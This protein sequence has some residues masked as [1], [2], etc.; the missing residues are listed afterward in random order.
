MCLRSQLVC[1][2]FTHISL[3]PQGN[4]RSLPESKDRI[5]HC[6]GV[7]G[8]KRN[9]TEPQWK[10]TGNVETFSTAVGSF[11]RALSIQI[12]VSRA[13][14]CI[15][16][17]R[18]PGQLGNGKENAAWGSSAILGSHHWHIGL[19]PNSTHKI[20]MIPQ[21]PRRA[22]PRFSFLH[23]QNGSG[24]RCKLKGLPL[25]CPLHFLP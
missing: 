2:A 24:Q 21:L 3:L 13:P 25:Q 17:L 5:F 20:P 6:F 12:S 19:D 23:Q 1:Y 8:S 14:G 9:Q 10:R 15:L 7:Q 11:A 18:S 16:V 22:P 4:P